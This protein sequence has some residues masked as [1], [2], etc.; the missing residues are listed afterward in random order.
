MQVFAG[1][2]IHKIPDTHLYRVII[3]ADYLDDSPIARS[4]SRF[5]TTIHRIS[6]IRH[7]TAASTAAAAAIATAGA[8]ESAPHHGGE[9]LHPVPPGFLSPWG[10]LEVRLCATFQR[11]HAVGDFLWGG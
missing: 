6:R 2:S 10:Q 9:R 4:S 7:P 1:E 8:P 3:I 5:P 11:F